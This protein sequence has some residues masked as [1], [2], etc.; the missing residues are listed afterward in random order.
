MGNGNDQ[1]NQNHGMNDDESS[2]S[3]DEREFF[4]ERARSGRSSCRGCYSTIPYNQLRFGVTTPRSEWQHYRSTEYYHTRCFG[5]SF[6]NDQR[7]QQSSNIWNNASIS[8]SRLR[9]LMRDI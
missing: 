7:A 6:R 3:E 9:A 1:N 5:N 4:I 8:A 2:E